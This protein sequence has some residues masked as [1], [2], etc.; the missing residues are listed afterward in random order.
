MDEIRL[1]EVK[2]EI[3]A[4]NKVVAEKLRERLAREK[5]FLINLIR[6]WAV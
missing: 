1:I 2:E 4:D 5:T 3:H 6:N